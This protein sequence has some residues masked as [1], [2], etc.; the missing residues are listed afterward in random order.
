[1]PRIKVELTMSQG[2]RSNKNTFS[3]TFNFNSTHA[4]GTSALTSAIDALVA[5]NR[6][7][8]LA[9][10]YYMSALITHLPDLSGKPPT[11]EFVAMELGV[12]GA[13]PVTGIPLPLTHALLVRRLAS[14]GNGGNMYVRGALQDTDVVWQ[15][16]GGLNLNVN[17][18][19]EF[20]TGGGAVPSLQAGISGLS[21]IMPLNPDKP[22]IPDRP[23]VSYKWSKLAIK[24]LN[25]KRT[26]APEA[27]YDAANRTVQ[28]SFREMEKILDAGVPTANGPA[29]AKVWSLYELA[30]EAYE[31]VPPQ[32]AGKLNF[33][34]I[35]ELVLNL[36]ALPSGD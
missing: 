2:G 21:P 11:P 17:S 30:R 4:L 1:M 36:P 3:Q 26:S 32:K 12:V 27:L 25:N 9:N 5:A 18:F 15:A 23:I 20:T 6:K 19:T 34:P 33:A 24:Q 22:E 8:H 16:G 28:V 10:I 7:F 35:Q 14:T 13:R 31:A 29:L